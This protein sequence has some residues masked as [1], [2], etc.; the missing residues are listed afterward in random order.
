MLD[1]LTH[2][3]AAQYVGNVFRLVLDAAD[4]PVVDL[5][6]NSVEILMPNRPRS[7]R[8]KRDAFSLF[9]TGPKDILIK[10]GMYRLASDLVTFD[11]IFIVPLGPNEDGNFEYE[12]VF[13]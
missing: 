2:D 5:T 7:K 6:L 1:T 10:Q 8:L 3:Q 4:A 11:M 12:A 13:T 9:F